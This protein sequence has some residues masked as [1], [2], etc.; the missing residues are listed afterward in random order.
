MTTA[1]H[2]SSSAVSTDDILTREIS[3]T[4]VLRLTLNDNRRRNALSE[5]MLDRLAD[6]MTTS[7]LDASIRVVVIAANCP[8]FCAGHDLKE[9]TAADYVIDL[10]LV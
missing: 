10:D 2:T 7:A 3:E 8:A 9:M 5:T 4:G 6:E 1:T